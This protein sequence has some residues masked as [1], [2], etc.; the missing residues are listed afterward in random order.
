MLGL[1]VPVLAQGA[2]RE[3]TGATSRPADTLKPPAADTRLNWWRAARFG[4]FVHWGPVSL[5]GTEIGWSRGR[6]VPVAE[7]DHLYERFNPEKFDAAAWVELA[8]AAGARYIVFTSKHHDGFSMFDTK[9]SD[10]NIM[11]SPFKRDVVRELADQCRAQGL[12]FCLYYS[13]ID[14]YQPDYLP[15]GAGDTRPVA[16]ADFNRYVA[17]MKG[18]LRE[19]LTGYGPVGILW[20]DGQWEDHWTAERGRELYRFCRDLQPDLIINNRVG[21]PANGA[22]STAELIGDY[23]TPEQ[24]IGTFRTDRP[25]ETCM[26]ICRQWA[27]KPHDQLKS[28]AE[29]VHALVRSAGGDG[30]FLLNLGPM[31]DGRIEPRQADRLREIGAWLARFGES[32]Y[33]TRGGP[34]VGNEQIACT[35]R[36]RTLYLHVLKRPDDTLRLPALPANIVAATALTGGTINVR[37][38]DAGAELDLSVANWNG[39]DIAVKLELDRPAFGLGP[40]PLAGAAPQAESP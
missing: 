40:I 34:Y 14:W 35:C 6:E 30:N 36:D 2:G 26:T 37:Q 8:K 9:L 29:C 31:P 10:Y 3:H 33:G 25:W 20:F 16:G 22:D 1:G 11:H 5:E 15:R 32:I 39:I 17:F 23:D 38:T 27:W 28:R 21:K 18:Q 4:M 12:R 13:I 24:Q 19:L 7:Y